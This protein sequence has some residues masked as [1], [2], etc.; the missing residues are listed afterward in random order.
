VARRGR[1]QSPINRPE[2]RPHDL[3]YVLRVYRQ[4]YNESST[5]TRP[6]EFANPTPQAIHG[7]R[8]PGF[9]EGA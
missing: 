1:K 5:S 7:F 2:F 3:E 9:V 4:H 6:A 8:R